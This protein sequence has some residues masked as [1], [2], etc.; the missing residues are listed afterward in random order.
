MYVQCISVCIYTC[1]YT[2]TYVRT[3]VCAQCSEHFAV[4]RLLCVF[5]R[6]SSALLQTH[7]SPLAL[8]LLCVRAALLQVCFHRYLLLIFLAFSLD[9]QRFF[10]FSLFLAFPPTPGPLPIL[11]CFCIPRFVALLLLLSSFLLV[12]RCFPLP[13][14]NIIILLIRF[15][16]SLIDVSCRRC[17]IFV[18]VAVVV[19]FFLLVL[20]SCPFIAACWEMYRFRLMMDDDTRSEPEV[21]DGFFFSMYAGMRVFL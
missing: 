2:C 12:P 13:A 21:R 8:S 16:F 4:C 9:V 17:S 6:R 18:A 14:L 20:L 7:S 5:L 15:L 11:P 10:S 1:I 19:F 3:Y